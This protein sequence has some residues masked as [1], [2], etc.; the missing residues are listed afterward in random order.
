MYAVMGGGQPIQL[1][2]NF[3]G[4]LAQVA[5]ILKPALDRESKRRG[6][7]FPLSSRR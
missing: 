4:D 1:T 6:A 3:G 5:R 2:L 7:S